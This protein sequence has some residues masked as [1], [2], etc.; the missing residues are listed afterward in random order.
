MNGM[1]GNFKQKAHESREP[2]ILH[3]KLVFFG[4]FNSSEYNTPIQRQKWFPVRPN[5]AFET[6]SHDKRVLLVFQAKNIGK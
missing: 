2:Q 5:T 1:D 4:S 6:L 3:L